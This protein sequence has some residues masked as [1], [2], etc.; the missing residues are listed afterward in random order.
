MAEQQ[1]VRH[2]GQWYV[3]HAY[4]GHEDKVRNNLLK[5]VESMDM[6]DKIF[7]VLVP[8]EEVIEI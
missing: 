6:A 4:S 3:V 5:R 2:D 1:Q 8:T 7:D